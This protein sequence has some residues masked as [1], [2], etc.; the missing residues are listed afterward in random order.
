MWPR[1]PETRVLC[2]WGLSGEDSGRS[3]QGCP[4]PG[5]ARPCPCCRQPSARLMSLEMARS[6]CPVAPVHLGVWPRNQTLKA[7]ALPLL[8]Q[9]RAPWDHV[10]FSWQRDTGGAQCCPQATW[11][12]LF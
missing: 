2:S 7:A 6:G 8:T 4:G 5:E 9:E 12:L 11:S 10:G 3:P 1:A